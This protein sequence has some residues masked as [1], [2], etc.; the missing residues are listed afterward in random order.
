MERPTLP[1]FTWCY[2]PPAPESPVVRPSPNQ[3]GRCPMSWVSRVPGVRPAFFGGAAGLGGWR[4]A[5]FRRCRA[6]HSCRIGSNQSST[7]SGID[8]LPKAKGPE[9]CD[10]GLGFFR[11]CPNH[12]EGH[13]PSSFMGL[14]FGGTKAASAIFL[15]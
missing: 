13:S 15:W 6:S 4:E 14:R 8:F 10:L 2:W 3:A 5:A 12:A 7:S 9:P 11:L 1:I